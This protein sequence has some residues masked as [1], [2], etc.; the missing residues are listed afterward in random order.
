MASLGQEIYSGSADFG[1]VW[2]TI[3]AV[4]FTLVGIGFIIW[5]SVIFRKPPLNVSTT[6]TIAGEKGRNMCPDSNT[7]NFRVKYSVDGVSYESAV[8]GMG[9][10]G[11][12]ITVYY[13][14]SNPSNASLNKTAPHLLGGIFIGL[15]IVIPL[16]AWGMRALIDRYKFLA[17]ASGA[18][19]GLNLVSGG[20][21]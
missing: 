5:G 11:E 1:R 12:S 2:A 6:G 4:I 7:C 19:V 20:R 14:A 15:G 9:I 8:S 3:T 16:I 18:G 17:A 13:N 21:L 10:G